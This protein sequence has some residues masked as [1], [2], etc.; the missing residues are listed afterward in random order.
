MYNIQIYFVPKNQ[1]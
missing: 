1:N